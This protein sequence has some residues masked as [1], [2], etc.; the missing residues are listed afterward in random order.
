ELAHCLWP[1]WAGL[2]PR[3]ARSASLHGVHSRTPTGLASGRGATVSTAL[4]QVC[5]PSGSRGS[6][7][8]APPRGLRPVD[9]PTRP[10]ARGALWH[11][12]QDGLA[13]PRP[14]A[15][16]GVLEAVVGRDDLP[17][18]VPGHAAGAAAYRLDH[19]P[20][21]SI[22]DGRARRLADRPFSSARLVC[23]RLGRPSSTT[24]HYADRRSGPRGPA[25]DHPA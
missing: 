1:R 12:R 8:T 17:A 23:R 25:G 15:A 4:A 19:P 16:L 24:P 14:V 18:R 5:C 6:V 22:P 21:V 2:W 11:H 3:Q 13:P 10:A 20:G 7:T 9:S